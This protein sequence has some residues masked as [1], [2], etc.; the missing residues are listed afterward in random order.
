MARIT[1]KTYYSTR[2]RS[3]IWEQAKAKAEPIKYGPRSRTE[4]K[5]KIEA[6]LR[7]EV[8]KPKTLTGARAKDKIGRLLYECSCTQEFKLINDVFPK[9]TDAFGVYCNGSG[10]QANFWRIG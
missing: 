3:G 4:P 2:T 10:Q 6:E 5:E 1:P 9:H 7:G 8:Y